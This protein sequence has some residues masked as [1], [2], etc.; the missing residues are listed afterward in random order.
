[1][2]YARITDITEKLVVA[3]KKANFRLLYIGIESFSESVLEEIGKLCSIEQVHRGLKILKDHDLKTFYN[4]I[5]TTPKS[6][7]ADVKESVDWGLKY[8]EDGFY[9][10]GVIPAI[11]PLKG[12]E[13]AAMHWDFKSRIVNIEDTDYCV[14][15]DDLIWPEDPH[16]RLILERYLEGVDAEVEHQAKQD[17]VIHKRNETVAIYQLRF[18]RKLLEEIGAEFPEA[19]AQLE[20]VE[21][22]SKE[23]TAASL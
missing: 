8:L 21:G 4:I 23:L 6:T 7:L 5:L 13:L 11:E 17:N 18:M 22:F 3:L 19:A 15:R 20:K 12:T 1:M 16:V 14:R 10:C 9:G 2:S